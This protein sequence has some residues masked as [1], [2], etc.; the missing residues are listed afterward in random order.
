M[1]KHITYNIDTLTYTVAWPDYVWEWPV[2]RYE[3][4]TICRTAIPYL[5]I[6][7]EPY[8]RPN[9][10]FPGGMQG[11]SRTYDFGY[12]SA[13]VDPNRREMKIGVRMGGQE[14]GVWRDLGG[15]DKRLIGFLKGSKAQTTRIDIAFDLFD[16]GIDVKRLYDDWKAGKID[17]RFRKAKPLSEGEKGADG[18]VSEATTVYFGSRTSELMVRFYEKG[19]E[20]HTDLDWVRVELEIKG[21]KA[22][23]AVE[24]C[25]RLGVDVVG[26]QL[27]RDFFTKMPYKFWRELL[28]GEAVALTSVGRKVTEREAW[29]RNIVIPVLREEIEK[30]WSGMVET[31]M[32]REIEALIREH[33]HTRMIAIRKQYGL[34]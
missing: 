28:S 31:G 24:D 16:Y 13:H 21:E 6:S 5:H 33:W 8:Q 15:D 9:G 32:T 29:I 1:T 11:Y 23:C 14:L 3:A 17:G 10:D 26:K 34:T 12:A 30:E 22:V 18:K 20:Q 25:A 19:K 2:E 7:G 27:L 4:L